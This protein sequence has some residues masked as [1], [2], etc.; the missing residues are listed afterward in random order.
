VRRSRSTGSAPPEGAPRPKSRQKLKEVRKRGGERDGRIF[1]CSERLND[2]LD[3]FGADGHF[4]DIL[5]GAPVEEVAQFSG[6][7]E[8]FRGE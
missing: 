8:E 3:G 5:T 7:S 4:E 6:C 1:E 2:G